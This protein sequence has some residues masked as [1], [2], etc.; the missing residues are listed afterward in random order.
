M[1]HCKVSCGLKLWKETNC[2]QLTGKNLIIFFFPAKVFKE[3]IS[4]EG[5]KKKP[6][7]RKENF[8]S[9][10]PFKGFSFA[11]EGSRCL[12][13]F[14]IRGKQQILRKFWTR[15]GAGL[16][17]K[18][19]NK[20]KPNPHGWWTKEPFI[21]KTE[22]TPGRLQENNIIKIKNASQNISAFF[23]FRNFLLKHH[24]NVL[25]MKI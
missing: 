2:D 18:I 20:L 8:T 14:S 6:L 12:S 4:R 13:D 9:T 11:M 7:K 3:K 15:C 21:K 19:N 16:T 1:I 10:K 5:L 23:Y 22:I 24:L 25:L 17:C